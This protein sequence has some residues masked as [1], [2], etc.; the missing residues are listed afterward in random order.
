VR[1]RLV[2]AA[3]RDPALLD[4][5]LLDRVVVRH[6][7][8]GARQDLTGRDLWQR[9]TTLSRWIGARTP[10]S[11]LVLVV[12]ASGPE[13]MA[14]FLGIIAAGRVAACF[15]AA[16]PRQDAAHFYVQ[17]RAA[18]RAIDPAA[19]CVAD[20]ATAEMVRR[21]D[22]ALAA[23]VL[24]VPRDAPEGGTA[25]LEAF[26]ARLR[27]DAP[28]F[29][30][31]S[32]G[33]TGIRKAVPVGGRMLAAQ[34]AAYWPGLRAGLAVERL[35][36][37]TWL[38]LY[39]DM[40]LLAGFL[41]PVL[42]GDCISVLDPFEWIA[43]PGRFL[44]MIAADGCDICW[45]PNFAFRHFTRLRRALRP[46]PLDAM[47]IWIDC[48]EPCRL[49]DALDF[50]A[51]FADCGL[52]P[53][54]VVGCYAMAETVFAVSQGVPARRVGL[55]VPPG[56]AVGAAL[57]DAALAETKVEETTVTR[58][59]V[60]LSSGAALPGVEI[61]TFDGDRALPE[62]HYGEIGLRAPFLFPA[63]RGQGAAVSGIG[64]D[65]LFRT[66]DLGVVLAG[67]VFVFGR[68]KEIVI[69]NGKN[70]FVHDVEALLAAVPGLRAGRIVAFGLDGDQTGSEEL[71][72]VAEHDP[73][74]GVAIPECRAAV[75]RHLADTLLVTPRDVRILAGSWLVKSSS[76][77]IS[78]DENRRRY[79]AEFRGPARDPE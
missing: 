27:D 34:F 38:P 31:H 36:I 53:G 54:S 73:G 25:A 74:A 14:L 9:A 79:L 60:V 40:G 43:A 44:E 22:P 49:A 12:G 56:V 46:P 2:E 17:Q 50:E 68:L 42:G 10:P 61:A 55:V 7:R 72:V 70:I 58:Q 35:S 59:R 64:P 52:R 20:A 37:A 19:I 6:W 18:L 16:S 41:L 57:A 62:G 15:P 75:S 39:H 1:E 47:R 3:L 24:T 48:S 67:Q 23:R 65:G 78:R 26:R 5:A 21:I 29:V 32:S 76:G 4:P 13:A 30:Q 66:G 28:I 8:Q 51:A 45:M 11:A 69:V 33:T 77:K 71:I 63:Y